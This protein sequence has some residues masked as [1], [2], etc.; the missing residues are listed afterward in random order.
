VDLLLPSS[1]SGVGGSLVNVV[2]ILQ[3][4]GSILGSTLNV[5]K[6]AEAHYF[7][8]L[9]R[10]DSYLRVYAIYTHSYL[11]TPRKLG[12]PYDNAMLG[13]RTTILMNKDI[14]IILWVV[15]LDN[16]VSVY[17]G[18]SK[19]ILN[20]CLEHNTIYHNELTG[21]YICNYPMVNTRKIYEVCRK[22]LLDF[23]RK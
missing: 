13:V 11:R 5:E 7:M 21:E 16:C 6:V 20:Y 2:E 18:K 19:L 15:E 3:K 23:S 8:V 10:G 12:I 4:V 1:I 14:D 22:T 17:M 9:R